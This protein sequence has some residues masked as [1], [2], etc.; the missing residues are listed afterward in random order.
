MP[1]VVSGANMR[2]REG[3]LVEHMNYPGFRGIVKELHNLR[4]SGNPRKVTVMWLPISEQVQEKYPNFRPMWGFGK[5]SKISTLQIRV[6]SAIND[7]SK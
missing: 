4:P 7:E 3:D 6:M 5:E 2:V 1:T